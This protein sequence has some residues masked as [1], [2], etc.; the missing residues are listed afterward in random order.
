[1]PRQPID[2][3]ALEAVLAELAALPPG[4]NSYNA[5]PVTPQAIETVRGLLTYLS[6]VP[7]SIGGLQIEGHAKGQDF[8]VEIA[9]DGTIDA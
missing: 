6:I 8:E 9:P 1:M 2:P 5:K 4:W 7:T 3:D